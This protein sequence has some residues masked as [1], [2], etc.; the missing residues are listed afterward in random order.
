MA[1]YET[2]EERVEALKKWWKENGVSIIAGL[3][4]GLVA[5]LG[6]R[7]WIDY[8]NTVGQAASS[9]FEQLLAST[10]GGATEP[11]QKQAD[12]IVEEY[13]STAYA[14]F[15]LL[16]KA[17]LAYEAGDRDAAEQLLRRVVADAP[18]PAFARV[19]TVRLARLLLEGG[20]PA[21]A[22][23]ALDVLEPG[24][25]SGQFERVRGDIAVAEGRHNDARRHYEAAL[26][27]EVGDTDLVR[28]KLQSLPSAS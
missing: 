4:I 11:A 19:A 20:N 8:R 24:G 23:A 9:M 17:R 1:T 18:E 14:E 15:A 6:W 25:F 5:V 21:A 27:A 22:A 2:D 13:G 16:V 10:L 3:V 12:L 7:G 28:L 26:E